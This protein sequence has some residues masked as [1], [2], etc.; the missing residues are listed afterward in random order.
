MLLITTL[1]NQP[2]LH[3]MIY[4]QRA[5]ILL[6]VCVAL[7]TDK[8]VI[9]CCTSLLLQLVVQSAQLATSILPIVN[10][11]T[12]LALKML[13]RFYTRAKRSLM[14]VADTWSVISALLGGSLRL[15]TDALLAA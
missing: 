7:T 9:K 5:D 13:T 6:R 1:I 8:V 14:T 12:T 10:S 11:S 2:W 3:R 4:M 15:L